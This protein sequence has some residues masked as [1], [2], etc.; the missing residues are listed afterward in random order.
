MTEQELLGTWSIVEVEYLPTEEGEDDGG[1]SDEGEGETI[2]A[3][4]LGIDGNTISFAPD[5]KFTGTFWGSGEEG[6]W[7]LA[8]G[9][10]EVTPLYDDAE[11]WSVRAARLIRPDF[12]EEH[13]R[14]MEIAYERAHARG[15]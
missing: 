8:D 2:S 12:D 10:L 1:F 5:G 7:R 11:Q 13:G 3:K 6:T 4:K 15:G 14:H 9:D